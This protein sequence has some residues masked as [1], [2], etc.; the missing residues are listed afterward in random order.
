MLTAQVDTPLSMRFADCVPLLFHD[1]RRGVIGMAHAGW[2]GTAQD[3]A[4]RMVRSMVEAWGCRPR[5]IEVGI[6]PSIGRDCYQVGE[7][8]V[9]ALRSCCGDLTGTAAPRP[10]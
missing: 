2:R 1:A 5:D 4:G 6:G 7:E 8:V 3:V 10:G 9:E